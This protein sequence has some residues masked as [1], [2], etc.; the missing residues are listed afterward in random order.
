MRTSAVAPYQLFILKSAPGDFAD[1]DSL[2]LAGPGLGCVDD[3]P[4]LIVCDSAQINLIEMSL[5]GHADSVDTSGVARLGG[6][7]PPPPDVAGPAAIEVNLGTDDD[8]FVGGPLREEVR[9]G[10]GSDIVAM[11]GGADTIV[12]PA[13]ADPAADDARRPA[14]PGHRDRRR[15]LRRAPQRAGRH[16][17]ARRQRR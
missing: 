7:L 13:A 14:G 3:S 15:L 1:P 8:R 4:L 11:G 10:L 12:Q 6:L 17:L 9:D 16:G 5:I 2:Q